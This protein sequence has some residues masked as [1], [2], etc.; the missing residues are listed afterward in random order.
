MGR[1]VSCDCLY[2]KWIAR[3]GRCGKGNCVQFSL[4]RTIPGE[5]QREWTRGME[6]DINPFRLPSFS[7]IVDRLRN[8]KME[9][10]MKDGNFS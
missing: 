9:L 4:G 5:D 10:V 3:E 6:F 8:S 7:S 1:R 2:K